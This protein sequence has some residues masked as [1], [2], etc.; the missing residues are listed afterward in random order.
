MST[1]E[2]NVTGIKVIDKIFFDAN[3]NRYGISAILLIAIGCM[4]G[5]AVGTGGLQ[6]TFQLIVLAIVTMFSMAMMLAI[7]PMRIV[8]LSG[9]AALVIDTIFIIIN[10]LG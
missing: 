2:E 3:L 4:G 9:V 1:Q 6:N 7:A 5:V 8:V 10:L